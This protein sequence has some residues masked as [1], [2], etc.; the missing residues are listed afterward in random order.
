[1]ANDKRVELVKQLKTNYYWRHIMNYSKA[2]KIFKECY[3]SGNFDVSKKVIS[4]IKTL[5]SNKNLDNHDKMCIDNFLAIVCEPTAKEL[6]TI[7]SLPEKTQRRIYRYMFFKYVLPNQK[8]KNKYKS[9]IARVPE[10]I[11]N[12]VIDSAIYFYG[13]SPYISKVFDETNE[14]QVRGAGYSC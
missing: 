12:I 4:E 11:A 10:N 14:V 9:W 7:N 6:K 8:D 3:S 5:L 13:C 2:E 1:L